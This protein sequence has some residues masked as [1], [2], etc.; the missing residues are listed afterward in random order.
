MDLLNLGSVRF[1][2]TER[3]VIVEKDW[4]K[5]IQST[6][7]LLSVSVLF[8]FL[9]STFQL[10]LPTDRPC[11]LDIPRG[12]SPTMAIQAVRDLP[13]VLR[14]AVGGVGLI[15]PLPLSS[16]RSLAR[17]TLRAPGAYRPLRN[18]SGRSTGAPVGSAS[19]SRGLSS[20]CNRWSNATTGDHPQLPPP[21]KEGT[22]TGTGPQQIGQI[23]PRL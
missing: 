16:P 20:S 11:P 14:R 1:A 2:S 7:F 23:E 18:A 22:G 19:G 6:W 8:R 17:P 12:H 9:Q 10:Y 15:R 13:P 21:K 5:S 3:V 4:T